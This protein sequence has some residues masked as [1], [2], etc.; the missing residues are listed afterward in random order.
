MS[1][2]PNHPDPNSPL[3][4]PNDINRHIRVLVYRGMAGRALEADRQDVEQDARAAVCKLRHQGQDWDNIKPQVGTIVQ[5]RVA[6]YWRGRQRGSPGPLSGDE[7]DSS[8]SAWHGLLNQER[9]VATLK[10]YLWGAKQVQRDAR[11]PTDRVAR[12]MTRL[13]L[14]SYLAFRPRCDADIGREC[15]FEDRRR[16]N[17]TMGKV[18]EY[19]RW[20]LEQRGF[21]PTA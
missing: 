15:G 14:R 3:D 18:R 21:E 11:S 6:D 13:L 20:Y 12:Q 17:E 10:A 4:L 9:R 5:R 1:D 2:I 19:A 7:S 16:V 8:R